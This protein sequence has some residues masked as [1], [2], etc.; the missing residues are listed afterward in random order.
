MRIVWDER[1]RLAN[2]EKHGLDF[3]DLDLEFFEDA[4]IRPAKL[5]RMIAFGRL[6]DG[7]IAVVFTNLGVEALSVISMRAANARERKI[8]EQA[9]N[10]I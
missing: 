9:Q 3:G 1:K 2:I 5:N 8:Y 10:G 6:A 4:V 7:T